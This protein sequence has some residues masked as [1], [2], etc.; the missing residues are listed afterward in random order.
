MDDD[1][2]KLQKSV[3][4][5]DALVAE[6]LSRT[7][8]LLQPNLAYRAKVGMLSTV[9][10]IRGQARATGYP[11]TERILGNCMVSYGQQLGAAS[12]FGGALTDVGGAL[13]QI[14]QARDALNI[15][16]KQTFIDPLQKLHHSELK[17]IKVNQ[18]PGT[19][20]N[21]FRWRRISF[22][23]WVMFHL[24][25]FQLKKLN[26]Q[27]LDLDYKKRQQGKVAAGELQR[28]WDKFS[29]STEMAERSMFV[30]LQ[31]EADLVSLLAA[32]ISGL[33][34]F[35]RNT[36]HILLGLHGNLQARLTAASNKPERRF[37]SRK[38]QVQGDHNSIIGLDHQPSD[39]ASTS[40]GERHPVVPSG[41][42]RPIS[43]ITD[44]NLV[45]D[46]P[47]CRAMYSFL[48]SHDGELEFSEGDIILLVRQVDANWYE[49]S[50]GAR[51]G[52]LPACYVDVLVPLPLP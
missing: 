4:V 19:S 41:L 15:T 45:L 37:R 1:F 12:E 40:S 42:S 48:P 34:D 5:I 31:N 38:V 21:T 24:V 14:G 44:N 11:Q 29:W 10:R 22:F 13:Q 27:R 51:S 26:S 9:S 28:A 2:Q 18:T 47:C 7:T 20:A 23:M 50:L 39:P 33:L 8:E 3:S 16:V 36:Q 46:Q 43:D 17:Q 49:G 25:Q 6:L 30:L 32:L 52:L 35:H